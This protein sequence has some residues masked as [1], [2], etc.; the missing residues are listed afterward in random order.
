MTKIN[1]H[2]CTWCW[3]A[4][5]PGIDELHSTAIGRYYLGIAAYLCLHCVY[6]KAVLTQR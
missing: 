6:K 2:T 1:Y 4:L 5:L 3:S